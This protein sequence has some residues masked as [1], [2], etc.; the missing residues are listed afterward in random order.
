[1]CNITRRVTPVVSVC[2]VHGADQGY[3]ALMANATK[4]KQIPAVF[5]HV[6]W[7]YK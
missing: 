4:K 5:T 2:A 3:E 6:A 7:D 1:M